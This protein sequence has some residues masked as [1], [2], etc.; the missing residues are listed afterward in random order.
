M[1]KITAQ[2]VADYILY[3]ANNAHEPITNLKLQKMVYYAQ[4]YYLAMTG[5]VLFE[6]QIEAWAHG[7]VINSLYQKYKHFRWQAINE[8]VRVPAIDK[9]IAEFLNL[10]INTFLPMDAFRLEQMTHNEEPW[11]NARG[12][13]SSG[14]ICRKPIKVSDMKKYFTTLMA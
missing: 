9:K 13:L 10:I 4:G 1:A 2:Q 3:F 6:D 11:I 8:E 5:D 12:K 14:A 7:P